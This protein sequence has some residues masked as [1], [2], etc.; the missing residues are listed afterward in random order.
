MHAYA[1]SWFFLCIFNE[2]CLRKSRLESTAPA[3]APT[4]RKEAQTVIDPL[5]TC[6]KLT[7]DD[8][9]TSGMRR[10]ASQTR[11]L[12]GASFGVEIG[13]FRL[14]VCHYL[15][16]DRPT[17]FFDFSRNLLYHW[18]YSSIDVVLTAITVKWYIPNL[19]AWKKRAI[20]LERRE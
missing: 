16:G 19:T 5:E 11:H 10:Y 7:M 6:M 12:Q 17:L 3:V 20:I 14:S 13:D 1:H 15:T 4:A 8:G 2:N 9:S 18:M